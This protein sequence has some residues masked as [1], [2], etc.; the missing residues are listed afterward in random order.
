MLRLVSFN[1]DYYWACNRGE[2]DSEV[3]STTFHR[4][5]II[6]CHLRTF[7]DVEEIKELSEKYRQSTSHPDSVYSFSNFVAYALYPPLY[8]A[9]PII[10]FNDFMW[11]V[12]SFFGSFSYN[13]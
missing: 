8:L 5:N 11:Q 3:D 2:K 7:Q 12:D 10:T 6:E 9:G 4:S 1:M 13:L